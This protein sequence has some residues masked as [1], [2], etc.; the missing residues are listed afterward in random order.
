MKIVILKNGFYS[1]LVCVF[2]VFIQC[3]YKITQIRTL[4]HFDN[5]PQ[6]NKNITVFYTTRIVNTTRQLSC[7][8]VLVFHTNSFRLST[9]EQTC[10][11]NVHSDSYFHINGFQWGSHKLPRFE[12]YNW[13]H[14][15]FVLPQ[16]KTRRAKR[17][18][19]WHFTEINHNFT[20]KLTE[21]LCKYQVHGCLMEHLF[22]VLCKKSS[23]FM[24]CFSTF[25]SSCCVHLQF[26]LYRA[27]SFFMITIISESESE[28]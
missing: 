13:Q 12:L 1:S 24:V 19:P 15:V 16:A 17:Q 28:Y 6:R 14:A 27:A 7:K 5:D 11:N 23:Q 21:Q 22:V 26:K 2:C 25:K 18:L 20:N 3:L 8:Y 10:A 4:Y 9:N